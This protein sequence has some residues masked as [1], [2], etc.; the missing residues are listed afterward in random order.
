MMISY[1]RLKFKARAGYQDDASVVLSLKEGRDEL[2]RME[3]YHTIYAAKLEQQQK[4]QQGGDDGQKAHL[5][6]QCPNCDEAYQPDARFCIYC[7][8]KRPVI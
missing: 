5:A 6:T 8:V 7:G 4:R 3:Y 1:V 2:E